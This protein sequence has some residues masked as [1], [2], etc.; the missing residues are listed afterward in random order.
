MIRLCM[1]LVPA[2]MV[3]VALWLMKDWDRRLR[4]ASV[5]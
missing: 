2:L 5:H 3:L 4:Q 1:G